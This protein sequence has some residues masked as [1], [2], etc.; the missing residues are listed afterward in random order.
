MI[1]T[2]LNISKAC[3]TYDEFIGTKPRGKLRKIGIFALSFFKFLSFLRL[4]SGL[5]WWSIG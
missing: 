5:P 4:K 1:F 3:S 2:R